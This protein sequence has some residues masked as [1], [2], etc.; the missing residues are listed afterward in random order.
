[1]RL[2]QVRTM[3]SI[4]RKLA[5]VLWLAAAWVGGVAHAVSD[6]PGGPAF[7]QLNLHPPVT[8]MPEMLPVE[9]VT[10][11]ALCRSRQPSTPHTD[12]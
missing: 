3:K 5:S 1:M 2:K 10:R 7:N 9:A 11:E 4:P 8:R 6:L 12:P